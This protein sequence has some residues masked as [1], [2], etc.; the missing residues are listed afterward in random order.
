MCVYVC[1]YIRLTNQEDKVCILSSMS[2]QEKGINRKRQIN[3]S[4]DGRN[5]RLLLLLLLLEKRREEKKRRNRRRKILMKDKR[6]KK[7]KLNLRS[8]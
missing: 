2:S 6:K 8:I 5:R 3:S 1:M 4:I 7:N